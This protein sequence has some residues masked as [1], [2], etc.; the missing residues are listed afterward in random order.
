MRRV[1]LVLTALLSILTVW[2]PVAAQPAADAATGAGLAP[3]L[4]QRVALVIGNGEYRNTVPLANPGNDA[5]AV[6]NML[7]GLGFQLVGGGPMRD[8]D[9]LALEDSIAAFGRAAETAQIALVFYAGHAIQVAGENYLIPIDAEVG[10]ERDLRRLVPMRYA[11]DEAGTAARLGVVILDACRD[12]PFATQLARA[13]GPSRS[14]SIG[15]GLSQVEAAPTD[16]L[17][18]YATRADDVADDGVGRHSP[19]TAALL[20][21]LPRPNLEIRLAFGA[22]RDTVLAATGGRQEPFI[23]G[24]LGAEPI[25]LA[26]ALTLE[27]R[28]AQPAQPAIDLPLPV[29]GQNPIELAFWNSVATSTDPAD[30]QAYLQAYPNGIFAVLA[31]NALRRLEDGAERGGVPAE[32][33]ADPASEDLPAEPVEVAVLTPPGPPEPRRSM[34]D[35]CDELASDPYDPARRGRGVM[36]WD[37]PVERAIIACRAA[38]RETP[39]EPRFRLQLARA[40]AQGGYMAE[41]VSVIRPLVDQ[42][43]AVADGMMATAQFLGFGVPVDLEEAARLARASGVRGYAMGQT[44]LGI[45]YATGQGMALDAA[46]AAYWLGLAAEQ[47][48]PQAQVALGYLYQAGHGVAA[49]DQQAVRLFRAAAETGEWNGQ[50]ELGRMYLRGR[51]VPNDPVEAA[52]WFARSL[53]FDPDD[54]ATVDFGNIDEPTRVR[55]VQRMLAELG[56]D[57]GPEDGVMGRRTRAA[58]Q[59]FQSANGIPRTDA[60]T[61]ELLTRLAVA[62]AD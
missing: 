15:R 36:D 45:L 17:V 41:A 39:G 5:V 40:L 46:K 8:L 9:R 13:L 47:D 51:G 20:E 16:V 27:P 2:T 23:Y 42:G 33:A 7:Q 19:F 61:V 31:T 34:G 57:P 3:A 14:T 54:Q 6:A 10:S 1:A 21:H 50:I 49:S 18:A 26:A 44:V 48:V 43:N 56:Y 25:Y 37:I 32:P 28:V 12:N 4:A 35:L 38:S 62:G 53:H 24:S 55:A 52:R 30:Y 22:V 11:I 59:A 29:G 60:I 58:I